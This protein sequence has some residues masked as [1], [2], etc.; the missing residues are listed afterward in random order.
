M[1]RPAADALAE[2]AERLG[3][4]RIFLLV[5]RTLNSETEEIA[6]IRDSLGE[7]VAAVHDGIPPHAPRTSVLEAAAVASEAGADLIVT[8]GGGSVTD[9]GKIVSMVMK[10]ELK[11]HD[12]MEPFHVY[13][14]DDGAVIKPQFDGPDVRV[15]C[16]PTTLSGGEFNPL[17]G[18]TD[19]KIG[20]KQGYEHPLMAPISIVLD[21]ALTVHTP[22]WLW[23]STGV[24]SLDHALE[25]LGSLQSDYFSDGVADSALRLLVEALP[26]VKADPSDLDA[27]LRCQVGAWQSMVPIVGGVPMGASHAIGHILG[28]TCDVPHGYCSCVMAPA[29][30]DFNREANESRQHRISQ[31]FGQP[32]RPA[33]ALVDEFISGLGMPRS[34]GEVGVGEDQ[35]DH[36]AEYTML[37]FWART[38]PRT[39]ETPAD[40]RKI[41][42]M[43]V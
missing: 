28:G 15:I 1:G 37:D 29:V 24:R 5:S 43:A 10:H 9:A 7:R 13:V 39:I 17:A 27:R 30:L 16:C 4:Q 33:G 32:D 26:A 22:E 35:L 25:T 21:P 8:V 2:E 40:V 31:C 6:R 3:A 12:D 42:D 23:T 18:A 14:D 41:L 11:E 38:N 36:I 19:E 20:H 34:L